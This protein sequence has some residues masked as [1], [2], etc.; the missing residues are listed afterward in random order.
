MNNRTCILLVCLLLPIGLGTQG[1]AA[2]AQIL[3]LPPSEVGRFTPAEWNRLAAIQTNLE[4][5]QRLSLADMDYAAYLLRSPPPQG[6]P[7]MKLERQRVVLGELTSTRPKVLTP[8]ERRYLFDV[9]Q[10]YTD[11]SGVV[12]RTNAMLVMASSRDPRA[13]A[14][15]EQHVKADPDPLNRTIAAS[16][17]A[18]LRRVLGQSNR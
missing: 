4:K 1:Q 11:S 16:F 12:V 3:A 8:A 2:P 14:V 9:V 15:L 5:T 18:H 13:I 6:T 17:L 10:P 7:Q